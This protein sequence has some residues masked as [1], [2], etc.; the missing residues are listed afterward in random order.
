MARFEDAIGQVL[1]DE[2]GYVNNA[3]DPGGETKYGI[4]KRRYPNVDIR[5][6]TV[7]QAEDLY[8]RDFWKFDGITSQAVATKLFDSYVN[9]EHTAIK[10]AQEVVNAIPDGVYGPKTEAAINAMDPVQFLNRYRVFLVQH[11]EDIVT[12]NPAEAVFLKGW[13]KRARE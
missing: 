2:G 10:L 13:L 4:S 6:L 7:Q 12:N 1:S 3:A 8:R 5:D 9:M 11:Y